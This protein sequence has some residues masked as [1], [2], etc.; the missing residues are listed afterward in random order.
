[1]ICL[2]AFLFLHRLKGETARAAELGQR[3]FDAMFADFDRS[4][5]EMG[6]GDLSV[7]R[8]VKRMA[9][10]FYGRIDA[11]ERGLTAGDGV[12]E[13]ALA[14]NLFGTVSA[15]E[16]T[17]DAMAR[18]LRREAR[19]LGEQPIARLMAGEISFDDPPVLPARQ[20]ASA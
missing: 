5:R 10:A 8:Q 19:R 18:Y 9:Q 17:L 6:T 4:L 1:M 15:E 12:L 2:H 16:A 14:R 11:Y 20:A 3:V 13:H 7:G